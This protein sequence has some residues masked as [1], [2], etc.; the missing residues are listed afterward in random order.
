[1]NFRPLYDNL[2]VKRVDSA[3][4]TSAGLYIPE[5][6]KDKPQEAK[7]IATGPGR[8]GEDGDIKAMT[9]NVGDTVLFGKYS[10]NEFKF[11]GEEHLILRENE[12]LA[13]I[14]R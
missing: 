11:D 13:I 4:K 5:S 7:V 10:G 12:V 14:E 1:M 9:V 2:L 3:E 6:A 8:L